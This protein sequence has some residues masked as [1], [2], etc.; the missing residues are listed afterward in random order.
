VT[1]S[2]RGYDPATIAL[3]REELRKAED[4]RG[5][6]NRRLAKMPPRSRSRMAASLRRRI[7]RTEVL[8]HDLTRLLSIAE[9][10]AWVP[11]WPARVEPMNLELYTLYV[12]DARGV[13]V[14]TLKR[15]DGAD[16]EQADV[17]ATE[18]TV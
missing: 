8:I 4:W 6:D 5:Y 12:A 3:L 16:V 10:V 2:D 7:A 13:Y 18:V 17:L 14:A 1:A 15:Y 11:D 9:G